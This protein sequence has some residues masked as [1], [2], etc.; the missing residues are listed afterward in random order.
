M[1]FWTEKIVFFKIIYRI[2]LDRITNENNSSPLLSL[3]GPGNRLK[4]SIPSPLDNLNYIASEED[5]LNFIEEKYE[6]DT[7]VDIVFDNMIGEPTLEMEKL[8]LEKITQKILMRRRCKRWTW[9]K[10]V[11]H[12]QG[13]TSAAK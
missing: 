4:E 3:L 7:P 11:Q 6:H 1:N 10:H 9:C 2:Y 5:I 8:I 13:L 12:L